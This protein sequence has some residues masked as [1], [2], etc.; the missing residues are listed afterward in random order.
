MISSISNRN[1]QNISVDAS[2]QYIAKGPET[3]TYPN[4]SRITRADS[5]MYLSTMA[6]ETTFK[7]FASTFEATARAKRVFPVPGAP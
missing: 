1:Q 5:P 2:T 6:L 4:I 7:K 3:S